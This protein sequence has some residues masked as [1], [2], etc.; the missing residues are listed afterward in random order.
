MHVTATDA[1]LLATIDPGEA[2]YGV[3]YQFQIVKDPSEYPPGVVCPGI[4]LPPG[5]TS[6]G[7]LPL[8]H[9]GIPIGFIAAGST[10]QGVSQDLA[11]AGVALQPGTTYHYR[12]IAVRR[13]LTEDTLEWEGPLIEGP[14]RTFTTPPAAAPV[15]DSV[16]ISHLTPT[17][18]TLE[19]QID[20]EGLPTSY[21]FE[22]WYSPCSHHGVGCELMIEIR[23]PSGSLLGSFVDQSVSLDLGSAGVTLGSGEYGFSVRATN[24]VG[25][26]SADGQTFEAPPGVVDPPAP[27]NQ[28]VGGGQPATTSGGGQP[29]EDHP[30]GSPTVS[31]PGVTLVT[32]IGGAQG[33]AATG[34]GAHRAT[35][36]HHRRRH[37][38][39]KHSAHRR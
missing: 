36:K 38:H 19:A 35:T 12:V 30:S 17:D 32:P 25:S 21:Q 33:S 31:S 26:V 37:K 8:Q 10:A 9:I 5:Y 13:V 27:G 4:T 2:Q 29:T 39:A 24:A 15:I 11:A 23:L 28:P 16:S 14:D 7:P 1:T 6:C 20:T 22:L 34:R 18:A 3:Y